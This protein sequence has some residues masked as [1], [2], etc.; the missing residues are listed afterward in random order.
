MARDYSA[1]QVDAADSQVASG[2]EAHDML[3]IHGQ[4]RE[5]IRGSPEVIKTSRS[6][7]LESPS[8]IKE[9]PSSPR[10]IDVN[11]PTLADS[12]HDVL[13]TGNQK[14]SSVTTTPH[15]TTKGELGRVNGNHAPDQ[16]KPSHDKSLECATAWRV[17][18]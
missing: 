12:S 18:Q 17:K 11:L 4:G 5:T 6:L 8:A 16:G 15:D 7:D 1:V 14:E 10:G 2:Q 9:T 3:Q 13:A